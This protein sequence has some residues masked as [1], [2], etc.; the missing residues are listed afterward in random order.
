[1]SA[2]YLLQKSK[3]QYEWWVVT[4]LN[5]GIVVRFKEKRFNETKEVLLSNNIHPLDVA[6]LLRELVDYMAEYHGSICFMT[7]YG[8]ERNDDGSMSFYRNKYPK[9]RLDMQDDIDALILEKSLTKA[10]KY[11]K[12]RGRYNHQI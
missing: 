10:I 4:D 1:M 2:R 6:R 3:E 8:I 7:P 11:L 9:W 5:N 12:S